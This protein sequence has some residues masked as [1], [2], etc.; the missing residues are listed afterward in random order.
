MIYDNQTGV[1]LS[2]N[3]VVAMLDGGKIPLGCEKDVGNVYYLEHRRRRTR[4]LA[5]S[6]DALLLLLVSRYKLETLERAKLYEK[7]VIYRP[8]D[9]FKAV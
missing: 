2:D 8:L 1:V 9:L 7:K 6:D 4:I 3:L 5:K